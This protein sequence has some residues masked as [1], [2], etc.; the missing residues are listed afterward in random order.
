MRGYYYETFNGVYLDQVMLNALST[1]P[2][3]LPATTETLDGA[4]TFTGQQIITLQN[5]SGTRGKIYYT[6]DGTD[7]EPT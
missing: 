3:I 6:I 2:T 5:N 1:P 4:T 7:P